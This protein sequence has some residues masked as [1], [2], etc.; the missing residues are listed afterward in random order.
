MRTRA[1]TQRH[2]TNHNRTAYVLYYSAQIYCV[3]PFATRLILGFGHLLPEEALCLLYWIL[4]C[5][6]DKETVKYVV[7][8]FVQCYLL[9]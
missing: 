5:L 1:G 6:V 2:V 9:L 3:M 7:G 4:I 8:Y